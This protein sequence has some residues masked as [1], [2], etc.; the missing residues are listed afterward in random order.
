MSA[1]LNLGYT[2][3]AARIAVDKAI[4][5]ATDASLEAV[6]KEALRLLS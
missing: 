3:K 6:I 4:S 1:L 2:S 5:N